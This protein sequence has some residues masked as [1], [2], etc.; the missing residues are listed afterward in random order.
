MSK[1]FNIK[2]FW[3]MSNNYKFNKQDMWEGKILLEDD[4]WFE[5]IVVDPNSS[6]K[7][8][9]FIFGVYHPEKIIELLKFTPISVSAPFVFHGLKDDKGY[10]GQFEQIGYIGSYPCGVCHICT[11]CANQIKDNVEADIEE[12]RS[13][14]DSYKENIMDEFGEEFY[15]NTISMR[16]SICKTILN[17]YEKKPLTT[18]QKQSIN[19]EVSPVNDRLT[20][21]SLSEVGLNTNAD[22][23]LLPF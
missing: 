4:G 14:I 23:E 1:L 6:Y 8:D 17:Q 3:N 16:S 11:Q 9:R 10:R 2:G 5:G 20:K 22:D 18:K 13:K 7:Q 15:N 21:Q 19:E 12:L